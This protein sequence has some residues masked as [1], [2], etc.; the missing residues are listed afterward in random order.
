MRENKVTNSECLVVEKVL[1]ENMMAPS[2]CIIPQIN[3]P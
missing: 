3:E 1:C 2:F